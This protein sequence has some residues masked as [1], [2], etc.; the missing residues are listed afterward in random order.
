MNI[1]TA[2]VTTPELAAATGCERL[3]C[4]GPPHIQRAKSKVQVLRNASSTR[5][6]EEDNTFTQKSSECEVFN[7]MLVVF[8]DN[9]FVMWRGARDF[10][11]QVP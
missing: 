6:H 8:T 1:A 7:V 9:N 10:R 4:A 3:F 5:V 2:N 11:L